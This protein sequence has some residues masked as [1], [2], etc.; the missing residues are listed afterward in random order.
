MEPCIP[1][2]LPLRP[3][4]DPI[5]SPWAPFIALGCRGVPFIR[6]L[7]QFWCTWGSPLG[8]FL[9]TFP[10][11]YRGQDSHRSRERFGT[12]FGPARCR[13]RC[14]GAAKLQGELDVAL[15]APGELPRSHL[16]AYWSPGGLFREAFS[17]PRRG[18][19]PSAEKKIQARHHKIKF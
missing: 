13:P 9:I 3:L 15:F 12:V 10:T 17:G 7:Q 14:A 19:F 16:L 8:S 4:W 18:R 6:F 5:R 1:W 11:S 2:K